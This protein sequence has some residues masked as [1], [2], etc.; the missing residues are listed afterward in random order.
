[1]LRLLLFKTLISFWCKSGI[2]YF[3]KKKE[4]TFGKE[5]K[6]TGHRQKSKGKDEDEGNGE[7]VLLF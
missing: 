6:R 7:S 2:R 4:K 3:F 5:G 1:M